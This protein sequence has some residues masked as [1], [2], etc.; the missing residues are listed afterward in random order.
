METILNL[1]TEDPEISAALEAALNE[2]QTTYQQSEGEGITEYQIFAGSLKDIL[3]L[4]MATAERLKPKLK[5]TMKK[6]FIIAL[7]WA[8]SSCSTGK[9]MAE[10]EIA[11]RHM[12][13][14][15]KAIFRNNTFYAIGMPQP[16]RLVDGETYELLISNYPVKIKY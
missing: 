2:R 12:A 9:P 1:K 6:L 10:R 3:F 16:V 14:K 13:V 4:G 15:Q 7:T 8:L 11:E 5:S